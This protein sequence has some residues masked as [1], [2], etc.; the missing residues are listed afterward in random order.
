MP[1]LFHETPLNE[2]L[3]PSFP[4]DLWQ[5]LAAQKSLI[6]FLSVQI[7]CDKIAADIAD[8]SEPGGQ[9]QD[10]KEFVY[11]F[12]LFKFGLRAFAELHLLR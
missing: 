1:F 10:M 9:R 5:K 12:F 8:D 11:D 2:S 7:Y 3:E 6:A 4:P